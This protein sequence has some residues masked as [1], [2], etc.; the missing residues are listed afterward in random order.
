MSLASNSLGFTAAT[1]PKMQEA[2]L[3]GERNCKLKP[4]SNLRCLSLSLI[5]VAFILVMTAQLSSAQRG[6]IPQ[7][8]P[9][10]TPSDEDERVFTEEVR[11][12]V[13][14][15]DEQGRF[16][17]SL[18][19]DDVLV[20]EDDI[21]QQVQSV[22][23]IPASILLL[24]GTGG[25]LNPAIRT[26]TTRNIALGLIANLRE[27]D[28]I[29]ALQFSNRTEVVQEWTTEKAQTVKALRNKVSSGRGSRLSQALIK[30]AQYLQT[31]PVGNRHLVLVTDGVETPGRMT[32]K[33][34]M[35][36]L[37]IETPEMR[38][39]AAEAIKQL[40][41][42]QATVHVISY[43][44]IGKPVSKEEQEHAQR[45]VADI[46]RSRTDIAT[47]GIDPTLPPGMSRGG[48][49]NSSGSASVRF[50]PQMKRLRKAYERAMQRGEDRLKSLAD[51]TGG[52]IW[53]PI[54]DEQML[55]QGVEVA[56]E[57][58]AQYVVTYRPKRPLAQAPATEYRRIRVSPRRIG[59]QLRAR[60]GYVV[61]AMR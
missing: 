24:L 44:T 49:N 34:A 32:Y 54:S 41:A 42:T 48:I 22:R 35:E 23:R 29:A 19:I 20:V 6:P 26:N 40:L 36:T 14:A 53:L 21:P 51:E 3:S 56:R 47:V 12:P 57:M 7:P 60:R 4:L 39:Q 55:A 61:G 30:A 2:P 5:A 59:L 37:G 46:A 15:Y 38:A 11:I 58:D 13:F 25:E 33:E 16:D 10:P 27:G 45:E 50:D 17:P 31:Q 28:S 8:A 43:T 1:F 18:E 9:T 52:R